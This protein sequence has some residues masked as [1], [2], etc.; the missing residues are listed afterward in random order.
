M[1]KKSGC[2]GLV[3]IKTITV[4][5]PILQEE[6]GKQRGK[7]IVAGIGGRSGGSDVSF[8]PVIAQ[9]NLGTQRVVDLNRRDV[10][11]GLDRIWVYVVLDR[12][13]RERS[14]RL[15]DQGL[16]FQSDRIELASRDRIA[17]ERIPDEP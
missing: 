11:L 5:G 4:G 14:L 12:V 8:P 3:V 2:E 1:H 9:L 13:G 10:V 15:R 7:T 17:R 16:N 6:I